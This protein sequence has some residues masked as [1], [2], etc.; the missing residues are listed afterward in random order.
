VTLK[1]G[2]NVLNMYKI[3]AIAHDIKPLV[4]FG[5]IASLFKPGTPH[6]ARTW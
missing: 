6:F 5:H 2:E 4:R 3:Y 1:I